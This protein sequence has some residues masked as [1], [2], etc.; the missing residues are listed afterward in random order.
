MRSHALKKK[1]FLA[2]AAAAGIT[3]VFPVLC[4]ASENDIQTYTNTDFAMDTDRCG[5]KP[6][7]MDQ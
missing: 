5:N 3:M 2:T 1:A 4:V 7:F 6:S